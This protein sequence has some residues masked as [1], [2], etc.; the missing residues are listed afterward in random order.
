MGKKTTLLDCTMMNATLRRIETLRLVPRAPHWITVTEIVE[1]LD[2]L[3]YPVTHNSTG[4][5]GDGLLIP[6]GL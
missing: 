6:I 3:D 4:P 5:D 2:A 1:R